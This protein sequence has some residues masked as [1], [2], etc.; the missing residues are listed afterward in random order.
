[1]KASPEL[2]RFQRL[3][4][5]SCSTLSPSLLAT[6]YPRTWHLST[7]AASPDTLQ[8]ATFVLPNKPWKFAWPAELGRGTLGH[9]IAWARAL[10]EE[11]AE[12]EGLDYTIDNVGE[13]L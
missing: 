7:H 9:Q 1:M 5:T 8:P 11:W 13:Q 10:V 6:F 12:A 2:F 4:D 3:Y